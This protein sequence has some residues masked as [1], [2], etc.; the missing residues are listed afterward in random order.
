[1][2]GASVLLVVGVMLAASLDGLGP[3]RPCQRDAGSERAAVR[4]ITQSFARAV[5]ELVGSDRHKPM[6]RPSLPRVPEAGDVLC[7]RLGADEPRQ[8]V[9]LR[10][11]LIDLPPPRR[12]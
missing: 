7:A 11:A 8:A 6:V 9:R 4:Q 2:S 12:A 5:R 1:M 10:S 3:I